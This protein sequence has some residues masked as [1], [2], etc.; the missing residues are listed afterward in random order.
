M[1]DAFSKRRRKKKEPPPTITKERKTTINHK[2]L[3]HTLPEVF[4]KSL[5][6]QSLQLVR[7]PP[8]QS[9]VAGD[10]SDDEEF[11][12]KECQ[13]RLAGDGDSSGGES[14]T[15]LDGDL[16][17]NGLSD[18]TVLVS[19][20]LK[21][22][23]EQR[24]RFEEQ[25]KLNEVLDRVHAA[26]E[27]SGIKFEE[28]FVPS[29]QT[30]MFNIDASKQKRKER[31]YIY[32][33]FAD[34]AKLSRSRDDVMQDVE[35]WFAV[36]CDDLETFCQMKPS[37]SVENLLCD[38]Y[39]VRVHRAFRRSNES[40][41]KLLSAIQRAVGPSTNRLGLPSAHQGRKKGG[42]RSRIN[43]PVP[44][45]E[46]KVE[47]E[48]KSS[49]ESLT[50]HKIRINKKIYTE[51]EL[52]SW[53]NIQ[54][55][56]KMI[57]TL[58][59]DGAKHGA[60]TQAKSC[61]KIGS[62]QLKIL[63]PIFER[64]IELVSELE[65][66]IKTMN[67]EITNLK[68][69]QQQRA[70]DK[71]QIR[72]LLNENQQLREELE[73]LRYQ[74]Q[75]EQQ[76]NEQYASA[77]RISSRHVSIKL[78][79]NYESSVENVATASIEEITEIEITAEADEV[80]DGLQ[81]SATGL[82]EN[83]KKKLS[84][85]RNVLQPQASV[86][87]KTPS[88][89]APS[90]QG[91]ASKMSV[92]APVPSQGGNQSITPI[93]AAKLS[94]LFEYDSESVSSHEQ[95]ES[96]M[97][98]SEHQQTDQLRQQIH[99]LR[100][101]V[102][103]SDDRYYEQRAELEQLREIVTSQSG[104][105]PSDVVLREKEKSLEKKLEKLQV[106]QKLTKKELADRKHDLLAKQQQIE[107]LQQQVRDLLREREEGCGTSRED[108]SGGAGLSEKPV[109]PPKVHLPL[110]VD[111]SQMPRDQLMK[112]ITQQSEQELNRLRKF[113]IREQQRFQANLRR[114]NLEAN[115]QLTKLRTEHN[116]IIRAVCHFKDTVER[117]L[118]CLLYTSPSPRDS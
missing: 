51:N 103:Q 108:G 70:H 115:K 31:S 79:D 47:P 3:R 83:L 29:F 9:V 98:K 63:M 8:P 34:S 39:F 64:K 13:K 44:Q 92:S 104:S 53:K 117:L 96:I 82:R 84:S 15:D 48:A 25:Q 93:S 35:N 52:N 5:T 2:S 95:F 86:P 111:I 105:K 112:K 78:P 61:Y 118:N 90:N 49:Q 1:S 20:Q 54:Q 40:V 10:H 91:V 77:Q 18:D 14:A 67:S 56:L 41:N 22:L 11:V 58:I 38:D 4:V 27:Y 106:Q 89:A 65:E 94:E 69:D 7:S 75:L 24:R 45:P 62:K 46:D 74:I 57:V 12:C 50:D 71:T 100:E 68:F 109:E 107:S 66:K 32:D 85:R 37:E 19:H 88:L 55:A 42:S 76:Q 80:A 23:K 36:S 21:S 17:L 81:P 28:N 26:L 73:T 16:Q 114:N 72:Q 110:S 113:V 87:G 102:R 30:D 43:L 6:C 97:R 33:M 59:S 101:E 99:L 116:Q 60:S